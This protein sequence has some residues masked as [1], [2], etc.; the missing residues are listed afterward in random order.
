MAGQRTLQCMF[1]PIDKEE[2]QAS[3]ERE[4]ATLE[5][6]LEQ[7]KEMEKEVIKRPVGRPKKELQATLLTPN[8]EKIEASSTKKVQVRG[9]YTNWFLPSLWGPIHAAMRVHKNYTSTLRYLQSKYK[10]PGQI[11]SVYDDLTRGTLFNWFTPFGELKEGVKQKIYDEKSSFTEGSQHK[12]VLSAYH[13]LREEIIE[14]LKALREAGQPLFAS[15]VRTRIRTLI[16]T[17]E[18]QLLQ[19]DGKTSFKVSLHWCREFVRDNLDWSYR[20]V[21]GTARKLP[22]DW[23]EQGLKMAYRAAYL[24][25]AYSIPEE[26]FVNT[27]QTGIH[28]VPT[29]GSYTWEKKGSK[30]ILIHG[31]DDKRQITVSVSSSAAGNVLPFQIVFTGSTTKCLPPLNVGRIACEEAGWHLTFSENHWSNVDTCKAFVEKILQPYRLEQIEHLK[32]DKGTKLIWLIDCWSV[33]KSKEF[34]SW[35]KES[36]QE[37]LII[38]VPANCTS[39][40][41][42]ADVILQKPF[43]HGFRQEFDS[44]TS[45]D[46]MKQLQHTS[47]KHIKVDTKMTA[48]KPQLCAWLFKAWQHIQRPHMIQ[49]G[50][51][52]CGLQQA[53]QQRF[54]SMAMDMN[55][56]TPLFEVETQ[57]TERDFVEK[58][59]DAD[60]D[61]SIESVMEDSLTR[62]IENCSSKQKYI[63]F[64][65]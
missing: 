15:S 10:L 56:K 54:Q 4:F 50:W 39:V 22:K 25:K 52:H 2:M 53:F 35:M 58:E 6:R 29:G 23:E 62:V 31:A 51:S 63:D 27:D 41:Q 12:Y 14:M 20:K 17:K 42:P 32:L 1:R 9:N 44:F 21:T 48:L 38:F 59:E 60:T 37:I 49:V 64:L 16:L 33:H 26:L 65:L 30:Y 28:L 46:I 45:D 61:H 7:E 43:K 8:V 40:F 19:Q 18:P 13:D 3:V 24:I 36:H 55:M 57:E 11:N 34:I 5:R 47:A